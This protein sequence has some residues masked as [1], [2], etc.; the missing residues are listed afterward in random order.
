MKLPDEIPQ[1]EGLLQESHRPAEFEEARR[2][3][4][5]IAAHEQDRHVWQTGPDGLER[6][7]A[8]KLGHREIEQDDA[9]VGTCGGGFLHSL[10]AIVRRLDLEAEIPQYGAAREADGEFVIDHQGSS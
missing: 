5:R 1:G 3:A 6:R 8:V 2:L 4:V 9:I 10:Q 7:V